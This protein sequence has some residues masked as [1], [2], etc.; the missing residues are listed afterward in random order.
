MKECFGLPIKISITCCRVRYK[1]P[2]E[3]E[4][5]KIITRFYAFTV[6]PYNSDNTFILYNWVWFTSHSLR[7]HPNQPFFSPNDPYQFTIQRMVHSNLVLLFHLGRHLRRVW[8]FESPCKDPFLWIALRSL[9]SMEAEVEVRLYQF[10]S[11]AYTLLVDGHL[12]NKLCHLTPCTSADIYWKS[13]CMKICKCD[14][15]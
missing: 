8:G 2:S 13:P 7:L 10:G 9:D 11:T 6:I 15:F 1:R 3:S 4:S 12:D 14:Q 5:V